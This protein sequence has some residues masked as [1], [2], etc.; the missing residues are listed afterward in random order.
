[1]SQLQNQQGKASRVNEILNKLRSGQSREAISVHYG[2]STWKS[3]DMYMRR[4]GFTW[5]SQ[6]RIY[7]NAEAGSTEGPSSA[8]TDLTEINPAE[9]IRLFELGILDAREIAKKTGF[10]SHKDMA[11]FMRRRGYIWSSTESNYMDSN[12]SPQEQ[13]LNSIGKNED[14]LARVAA[15]HSRSSLSEGFPSDKYITLLEFLWNSRDKLIKM[16]ESIEESESH[17]VQVYTIPGEA[18]TKSIFFSNELATLMTAFCK[19]HSM[20][21]KQGFEAAL[22]E[23]LAQHGYE[24]EINCLLEKVH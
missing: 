4:N 22:I 12:P 9:I 2:Y 6:R 21:Q 11:A 24:H 17:K 19:D 13:S 10:P 1:M 8:G 15:E 3:L 14:T 18:K 5:D 20:S 7:T 23:Y 16:I